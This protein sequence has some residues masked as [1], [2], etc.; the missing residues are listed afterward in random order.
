ML[1]PNHSARELALRCQRLAHLAVPARPPVGMRAL[2]SAVSHRAACA[3]CAARLAAA[4]AC[5][6][7]LAADAAQLCA[8]QVCAA[9]GAGSCGMCPIHA[10][11][12]LVGYCLAS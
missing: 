5:R 9:A 2:F 6:Q 4:L 3:A 8:A 7:A 1:L 10:G 11:N 12:Y